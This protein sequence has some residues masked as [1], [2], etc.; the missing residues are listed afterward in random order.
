MAEE[1]TGVSEHFYRRECSLTAFRTVRIESGAEAPGMLACLS[2]LGSHRGVTNTELGTRTPGA[3]SEL[4]REG[5]PLACLN[6]RRAID[7]TKPSFGRFG[8]T[9]LNR[10][11]RGGL[12][13]CGKL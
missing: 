4:G 2:T 11:P 10:Y 13:P 6:Q 3:P 5:H 12:P 1:D 7:G 9:V 8:A